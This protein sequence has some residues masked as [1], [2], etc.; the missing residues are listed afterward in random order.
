M[1][2]RAAVGVCCAVFLL[3]LPYRAH[4]QWQWI[5]PPG[6]L[7][8]GF[9]QDPSNPNTLYAVPQASPASL[10]KSTDHGQHWA[11][12]S[13]VGVYPYGMCI[14][15]TSPSTLYVVGGSIRRSTN[16]GSSWSSV[17]VPA[18]YYLLDLVLQ[19]G[20][21]SILHAAGYRYDQALQMPLLAHLKSTNGGADWTTKELT[22]TYGYPYAVVVDP[23][24]TQV[25]YVCGHVESGGNY[26]GK[27]FKSSNGG[28]DFV[29]KTGVITGYVYDLA[30]DP[31]T[32]G[33][34]YAVS[35]SGIYR[36]TDG[37]S[38]WTRNTGYV[39]SPERIAICPSSPS[40]LYVGTSMGGVYKSTDGGVVWTPAA[41]GI[42]GTR[43]M[44]LI[45][46]N[47][48]NVFFATTAGVFGTTDGGTS[49]SCC[50]AGLSA[51]RITSVR[52]APSNPAVVY[53]GIS[54]EAVYKTTTAGQGSVTWERIPDFY[55]CTEVADIAVSETS[56][57][58][59][60]ALEGGT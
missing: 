18:S 58:V 41:S 60:Y 37:G 45:V 22:T 56:P 40:M 1:T 28:T 32:A 3:L 11:R 39:P 51:T 30:H 20:N 55:S 50:N 43:A 42:Y 46:E 8:G 12:M 29:D 13:S 27:V 48:S 2:N 35:G 57:D 36:T 21:P 10:F 38:T 34:L 16:G 31:V 23:A 47:S 49:W 5:G 7:L 59:L 17:N 33:K 54:G 53:V 15:P 24:N 9:A 4:A 19:P 44:G 26:Y 14:H 52:H 25:V 6:G